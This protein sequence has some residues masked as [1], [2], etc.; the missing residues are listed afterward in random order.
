MLSGL[1]KKM[2]EDGFPSRM[3]RRGAGDITHLADCW[4]DIQKA[5][6]LVPSTTETRCGDGRICSQILEVEAGRS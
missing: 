6:G 5:P 2:V 4:P 1:P 3:T